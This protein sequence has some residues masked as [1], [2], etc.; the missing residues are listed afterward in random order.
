MEQDALAKQAMSC[1]AGGFIKEVH[2][3]NAGWFTSITLAKLQTDFRIASDVLL[4]APGLS[5]N[6]KSP[7]KIRSV[8]FILMF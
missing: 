1:H 8:I 6:I 5:G 3:M 2:R 4:R 7:N